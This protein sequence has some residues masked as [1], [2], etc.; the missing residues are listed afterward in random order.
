MIDSLHDDDEEEDL[1]EVELREDLDEKVEE[2]AIF[3]S[4][5]LLFAL[6]FPVYGEWNNVDKNRTE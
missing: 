3:S 5:R 6:G 4:R 2:G 1:D